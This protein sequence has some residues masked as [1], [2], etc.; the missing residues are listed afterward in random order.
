MTRIAKCCCSCCCLANLADHDEDISIGVAVCL[1]THS[2][3]DLPMY[4]WSKCSWCWEV[5]SWFGQG[6]RRYYKYYLPSCRHID[7]YT[8]ARGFRL[9]VP[10]LICL[11][12]LK[13]VA[14]ALPIVIV[15]VTCV[16]GGI[17]FCLCRTVKRLKKQLPGVDG[18]CLHHITWNMCWVYCCPFMVPISS[19]IIIINYCIQRSQWRLPMSISPS[20]K[21]SSRWDSFEFAIGVSVWS[22]L[23][24]PRN[25]VLT[26][27][28]WSVCC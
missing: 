8:R 22:S 14:I 13:G 24:D 26:P 1:C 17:I 21:A 23:S 25:L 6:E 27:C 20:T 7:P 5:A 10:H 11:T 2:T 18:S 15:L 9:V 28:H 3:C 16:A 4:S 19:L 12:A